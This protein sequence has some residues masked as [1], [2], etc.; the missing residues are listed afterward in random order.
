MFKTATLK[1]SKGA[2][3][4]NRYNQ[5]PHIWY[6][7]LGLRVVVL[8]YSLTKKM[9]FKTNHRRSKALQNA[10]HRKRSMTVMILG[11]IPFETAA[12][13]IATYHQYTVKS[14]SVNHV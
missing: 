10:V 12:E 9:V 8:T 2:K 6:L 11:N 5:I 1:V 4:R 3:I 14:N 7:M 13:T